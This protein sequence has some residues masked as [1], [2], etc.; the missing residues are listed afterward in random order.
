MKTQPAKTAPH[1]FALMMDPQSVLAAVECSERLQ[2][3]S[4]H[5][6]R[7]LDKPLIPRVGS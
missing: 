4:R 5:V 3:L 1:P 6:Y 7:P 2:G